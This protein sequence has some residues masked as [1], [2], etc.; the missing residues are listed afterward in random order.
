MYSALLVARFAINH[1]NEIKTSISNLKLQKILYFIQADFLVNKNEPCFYEEIEAWNLGPV[2][3]EVYMAF[4]IYGSSNIPF[5]K[6]YTV[7]EAISKPDQIRIM[8]MTE[9]CSKYSTSALVDITHK[10][11]PWRNAYQPY[12]SNIIEKESIKKYFSE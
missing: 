1:C 8:N 9:K 4:K 7:M 11:A 10:Q 5:Q 2:V 12:R 3:P 6:D